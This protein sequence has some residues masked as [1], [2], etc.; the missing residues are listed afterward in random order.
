MKLQTF[1][2]ST[3]MYFGCKMQ[4]T[5][6]VPVILEVLAPTFGSFVQPCFAS[7]SELCINSENSAKERVHLLKPFAG[8]SAAY[9][10]RKMLWLGLQNLPS[11]QKLRHGA[12]LSAQYALVSCRRHLN[13]AL[14]K[15]SGGR[16]IKGLTRGLELQCRL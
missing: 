3:L 5:W 7:R 2:Y 4:S 8:R 9:V 10:F 15:S 14:Q 6:A 1:G 16:V 11:M 12:V 13:F